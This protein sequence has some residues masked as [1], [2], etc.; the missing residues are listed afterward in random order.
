MRIAIDGP[1]GAG[2]STV[3]KLLAKEYEIDYVDTGAMYRAMGL[4]ILDCG[5]ACEEGP[6]LEDL[7]EETDVDYRDWRV[8]LDGED[9]S[10]YIR[11]EEVS[12]MASDCSAIAAVRS[13]LDSIQKRIGRTRSVVMDGRD[14]CTVVMPHAEHKF[15]ITA[16]AEE[17]ARR[18]YLEL[19]EKGQDVDYEKVLEDI[20]K[21]DYNDMNR[22]V[23]PLRIADDAIVVDTT[24]M[25]IEEVVQYVKSIIEDGESGK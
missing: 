10:N 24:E 3:A 6:E 2:K 19:K 25:S 11:T 8:Y 9:V 12:K 18:R 22:D 4:K 23:N 14:I 16:T 7:L 1:S 17:R 5:I 15:Y 20:N 13:K 21:R